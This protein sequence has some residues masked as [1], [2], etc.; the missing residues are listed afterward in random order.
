MHLHLNLNLRCLT[1]F[2]IISDAVFLLLSVPIDLKPLNHPRGSRKSEGPRYLSFEATLTIFCSVS[3]YHST[4]LLRSTD[5]QRFLELTTFG[6]LVLA[7]LSASS[8]IKEA[9]GMQVRPCNTNSERQ[10][11]FTNTNTLRIGSLL[12]RLMYQNLQARNLSSFF[13]SIPIQV[14]P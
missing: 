4:R 11:P 10:P 14:R 3:C 2:L 13:N 8:T 12:P 5:M 6:S 1:R 9:H 7:L